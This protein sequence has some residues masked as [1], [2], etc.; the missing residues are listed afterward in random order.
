MLDNYPPGAANDPRAPWNE[1]PLREVTVE[2]GVELGT[3]VTIEIFE[4]SEEDF[5]DQLEQALVKKFNIDNDDIVLNN[6]NV[7][8]IQ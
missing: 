8:S 5:R 2:V 1:P 7:Y 4:D 3:M 6:L